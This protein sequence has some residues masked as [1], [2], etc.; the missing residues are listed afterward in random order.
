VV[1]ERD[2]ARECSLARAMRVAFSEA[3]VRTAIS[4]VVLSTAQ[5]AV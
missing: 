5:R 2:G 1:D 4:D 3:P